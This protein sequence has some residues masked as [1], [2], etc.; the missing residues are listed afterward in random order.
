[1]AVYTPVTVEEARDWLAQFDAGE[2]VHLMP[3]VQGVENTNYLIHSTAGRYILTMF[4]KRTEPKDIPFFLALTEH[5]Y[6]RGIVCPHTLATRNGERITTLK[7]K[8]AILISF[9]EG[10]DT[11]QPSAGHCAQVG[12]LT[13]R[14]HMAAADFTLSRLNALSVS[15][16]QALAE[17]SGPAMDSLIPGLWDTVSTELAFLKASW[18]TDLPT[19]VVHADLFPDNVFFKDGQVSGVIDFYFACTE[20]YAYDLAICLN[21]WCF[22]EHWR[23]QEPHA[24]AMLDAYQAIR[25]LS[26]EEKTAFNRLLRG[27][28]LRFLLSRAHDKLFHPE[29]S[30][31]NPKD[32]AEYLA[33]LRF[34]QNHPES[35]EALL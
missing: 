14:M 19:G 2:L 7:A 22:D 29:G 13:A 16:W 20:A 9:L 31:V 34:H 4:E 10:K 15:G 12:A 23:L 33:K 27:A 3:I 26:E 17:R 30:I 24:R 25:P 21:A 32:P 1:M 18:P 28:S 8:P 6:A 5:L 11:T 35:V